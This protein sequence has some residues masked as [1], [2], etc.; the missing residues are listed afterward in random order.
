MPPPV[1]SRGPTA[2]LAIAPSLS[3]AWPSRIRPSRMLSTPTKR[4]IAELAG[5]ANTAAAVPAL[6]HPAPT[7]HHDAVGERM[8][9]GMVVG[10]EDRR[11]RQGAQER[12]QL[13]AQLRCGSRVSSAEN[14]SSNRNRFRRA[15]KRPRQRH[16]LLFAGAQIGRQAPRQMRDAEMM[17]KRGRIAAARQR[18]LAGRSRSRRGGRSPHWLQRRDEETARSSGPQS[19]YSR[20]SGGSAVTSRPPMRTRPRSGR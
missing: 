17:Q 7:Q 19:R 15:G 3:A 12:F 6:H 16:A 1:A 18:G 13:A 14:G 9:L 8:R 10:D 4:A 11:N 2:M 20:R 5:C